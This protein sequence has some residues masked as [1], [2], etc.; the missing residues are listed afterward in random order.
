MVK[1]RDEVTWFETADGWRAWLESN[2]DRASSIWL[3]LRKKHLETGV[4]YEDALLEALCFGWIDGITHAVDDDGYTV[5]FTPRKPKSPWSAPN[6]ARVERLLAEGRMRDAGIRAWER[7]EPGIADGHGGGELD[8][9]FLARFQADEEAWQ[10]F[11]AC[12]PGYRRQ[13][14]RWVMGAKRPETRERRFAM[15]IADAAAGRRTGGVS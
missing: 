1:S 7:R 9:G 15:L 6:L 5:R 13:A 11:S 12:P 14:A 4:S 8:E 2:H 3:G 10:W